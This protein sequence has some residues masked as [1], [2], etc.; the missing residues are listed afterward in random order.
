LFAG[1]TR[2]LALSFEIIAASQ[3]KDYAQQS[4][5]GTGSAAK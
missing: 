3:A 2:Q 4:V 5:G 1:T